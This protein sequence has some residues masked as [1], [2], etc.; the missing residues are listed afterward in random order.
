[1]SIINDL[2]YE[3]DE[4]KEKIFNLEKER[5]NI[6]KALTPFKRSERAAARAHGRAWVPMPLYG[7]HL[8]V[9]VE[10]RDPWKMGRI[11]VYCP[12]IHNL[13]NSA[14][15]LNESDLTWASPCSAFGS[16]DD[17]GAIFIPPEGSAV[18]LIFENGHRDSIYYLG[19]TWVPKKSS[20]GNDKYA[21]NPQ[22]ESHRWGGRRDGDVET[23]L[24]NSLLPQWNNESY[25]GNDLKPEGSFSVVAQDTQNIPAFSSKSESR[26]GESGGNYST[27][28]WRSRDIPHMYGIKTPEKHFILFDDGS[29]EREQKLWGKD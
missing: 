11:M 22:R 27:E 10:T 3:I 13:R 20:P 7:A 4:L 17:M 2:Q 18:V 1:M 12:V 9:C 23:G 19:S 15:N 8:G 14:D 21:F 6:P 28:G 16:I 24:T 5:G 25:Y 29:Y 26:S